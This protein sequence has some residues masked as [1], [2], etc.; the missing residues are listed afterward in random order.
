M[1]A[2]TVTPAVEA[3]ATAKELRWTARAYRDGDLD[4]AWYALAATD[5]PQVNAEVAAEA[6]RTRVFCVRADDAPGA[7]RSPPP[8]GSTTG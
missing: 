4:G 1:V 6:E 2:P 7:P 3:M 5:D 8:S